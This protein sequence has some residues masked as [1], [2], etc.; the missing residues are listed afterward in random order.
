[1][2]ASPAAAIDFEVLSESRMREICMSGSIFEYSKKHSETVRQHGAL[3]IFF[4]SWAYADKPEM[5]A[6]LAEAYTKAAND[7]DAF[8]IPA[9]LAFERALGE[10]PALVLHAADRRH[11]SIAGTYLAAATTYAA[12]FKES[13]E[14]LNYTAGLDQDTTKFLQTVAWQTVQNYF[15]PAQ[16]LK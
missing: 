2:P 7:N 3:P 11:P 15:S 6:Q 1:M 5:S 9:G 4:M 8:V 14:G 10:R 12:L 13:P 16:A